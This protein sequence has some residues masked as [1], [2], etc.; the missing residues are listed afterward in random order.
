[1]SKIKSHPPVSQLLIG[2]GSV[3]KEGGVMGG[4]LSFELC[5]QLGRHAGSV[6]AV[7]S[8]QP[9]PFSKPLIENRLV[10]RRRTIMKSLKILCFQ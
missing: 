3:V 5:A 4:G 6:E 8:V 1:M 2:G 9:F 10:F 7:D